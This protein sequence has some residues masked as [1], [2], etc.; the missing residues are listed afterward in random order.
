MA[1]RLATLIGALLI[2]T[3]GTAYACEPD[4]TG[5]T[6]NVGVQTGPFVA[7]ALRIAGGNRE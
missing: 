7:S 2:S 5:V 3:A 4:Y 6:L 1:Y